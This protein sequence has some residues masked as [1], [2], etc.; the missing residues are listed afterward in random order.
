VNKLVRIAA[1]LGTLAVIGTA[2]PALAEP[3]NIGVTIGPTRIEVNVRPGQ[4][5]VETFTVAAQSSALEVTSEVVPLTQNSRGQMTISH[6]KLPASVIGTSRVTVNPAMYRLKPNASHAFKVTIDPPAHVQPG[7]RALAVIFTGSAVGNKARASKKGGKLGDGVDVAAS[8]G[9]EM[10]LNVP[11]RTVEHT[12]FGL[13][14]PWISFGGPISLTA[15]VANPGNTLA[16]INKPYAYGSGHRIN[17]PSMLLLA[18][19]SR[20]LQTE[21]TSAGLGYDTVSWEGQT[22]LVIV[23]PL[24]L[25]LVILGIAAVGTGGF[26][27]RRSLKRHAK[28]RKHGRSAHARPQEA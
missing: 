2:A 19:A 6:S 14:L 26:I 22:A 3:A 23:I 13:S 25:I 27:W 28:A 15:T 7:Q 5:T 20:T 16:L 17:L 4:K 18:G 12:V 21:W 10:I 11:G 8:V 9:G 24:N 1:A